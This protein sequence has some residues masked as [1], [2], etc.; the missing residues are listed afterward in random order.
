MAEPVTGPAMRFVIS[1][2]SPLKMPFPAFYADNLSAALPFLQ[3]ANGDSH[4]SCKGLLTHTKG[5]PVCPDTNSL[6]II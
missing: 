2:D 6:S 1:L 3:A 5:F 4:F